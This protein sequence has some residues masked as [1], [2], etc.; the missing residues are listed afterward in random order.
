[1]RAYA[2]RAA[3]P[4]AAA[5]THSQRRS[6]WVGVPWTCGPCSLRRRGTLTRP[7][8]GSSQ[9]DRVGSMLRVG[10]IVIRVDDL[11]R[12]IE[13]W[14]AALDY[15]PREEDTGDFVLLRPRDGVG[16][17]LSL[18][19]VHS[20]GAGA[21]AD[22]PRPIR[23]GPGR[24]SQ[25]PR[26]FGRHRDPLGQTTGRRG[27]RHPGGPGGEPLL[28]H[29]RGVDVRARRRRPEHSAVGFLDDLTIGSY[30]PVRLP[31]VQLA[32]PAGR[33]GRA[34]WPTRPA[35]SARRPPPW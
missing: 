4:Y 16:P 24:G 21:T 30:R 23:G 18:D 32:R 31:R 6:G 26:R 17:N 13:F 35:G 11:S 33:E 29:R 1:M 27:L 2:D 3:A 19:R 10:S 8:A 20:T 34:A 15:V 7:D 22:P 9:G 28:R 5:C 25:A 12:Q 14:A